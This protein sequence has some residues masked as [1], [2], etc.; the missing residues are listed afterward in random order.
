MTMTASEPADTRRRATDNASRAFPRRLADWLIS[1]PRPQPQAIVS[2]LV[3]HSQTKKRTLVLAIV[4]TLAMIGIVAALT[5]AR[6][7]YAW[8]A[9]EVLFGVTRYTALLS[10]EKAATEDRNHDFTTVT[11]LGLAWAISFS[12]GC[13][14]CV[15]SGE[16]T[17][18]LLAGIVVAGLSGG[19]SSRNAGTPR[20][21]IIMIF[22][23]G[24]PLTWALILSPIPHL[25]IVAV[26]VP[27]YGIG[28]S[29]IL[30]E[31]YQVLLHLFL[32]EQENRRLANSDP[33]TALPNRIMKRKRFDD[34][35]RRASMAVAGRQHRFAVF[36]LDLDGFKAANDRYG[37]AAGD[38]VLVAVAHRLRDA[39]RDVDQIFRVGGDEF[40]ILLPALDI[41][42]AEAVAT[43]IIA[44]ISQPFDIGQGESLQIG[45]SIGGAS[46]PRD[47]KT[48]DDLLKS[49]DR[50]MYEAKHRGKGMFVAHRRGASAAD[51]VPAPRCKDQLLDTMEYSSISND[52]LQVSL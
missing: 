43:R 46:Y 32:S 15:A 35:L 44:S 19:I 48:T 38:A 3:M 18:I 47:G 9:I 27:F 6:W 31:N 49:A 7:A 4:S 14:L 12:I 26:L 34:M 24:A 22:V 29:F 13:G 21:G 20:H 17:A 8:F 41:D 25:A 37:H 33:L 23:L 36:C 30:L 39:I 42:R 45:V 10:L 5:G 52:E 40:V 11:L 1:G 50:A 2:R 51:L 28:V 16:I